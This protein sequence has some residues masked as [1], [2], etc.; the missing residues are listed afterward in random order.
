MQRQTNNGKKGGL[1]KGKSHDDGGIQAVVVDTGQPVE[2]EG[3][4]II[5]NKKSAKKHRKLLSKIN[6]DGGGVPILKKGGWSHD[7]SMRSG[8]K[9]KS[10]SL[11]DY[12]W[13]ISEQPN[14]FI[15]IPKNWTSKELIKEINDFNDSNYEYI[16]SD[17]FDETAD[18]KKWVVGGYENKA[19]ESFGG[20]GS[21]KAKA[22]EKLLAEI[23]SDFRSSFPWGY[24]DV[25]ISG[26]SVTADE[27]HLGDW[28]HDY[29][30]YDRDEDDYQDDDQM[31]WSDK[32]WK[33]YTTEFKKWV[34]SKSWGKRVTIDVDTSEKNWAYFTVTLKKTWAQGMGLY[35]KKTGKPVAKK[36]PSVSKP[37]KSKETKEYNTAFGIIAASDWA[38]EPALKPY[39]KNNGKTLA[40]PKLQALPAD[41]LIALSK[42]ITTGQF[43]P[44]KKTSPKKTGGLYATFAELQKHGVSVI[45]DGVAISDPTMD[46]SGRKEVEIEYY[47]D[48][49]LKAWQEY[50]KGK[51][52]ATKPSSDNSITLADGSIVYE[53]DTGKITGKKD[54][55][56]S[57]VT[58]IRDNWVY[59]DA[60]DGK[61]RWLAPDAF[62]KR[63]EPDVVTKTSDQLKSRADKRD[64]RMQDRADRKQARDDAR[65]A[66]AAKRKA[67]GKPTVEFD[68]DT[69]IKKFIGDKD[70]IQV[71]NISL[72]DHQRNVMTDMFYEYGIKI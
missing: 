12:I 49:I 71:D 63:F 32:S 21:I 15:E 1:L 72:V 8:G 43:A 6:Q 2:L 47:K 3:E 24:S 42:T 59:F 41:E 18:G 55:P 54:F 27:R 40:N 60:G 50:Q 56:G 19:D 53:G 17:D 20:G 30:D 13:S 45:S 22:K 33:Y 44:K 25:E 7:R 26:D 61:R 52:P 62:K 58:K 35:P 5:I 38:N 51:K 9:V 67:D 70:V 48:A 69:A 14:D 28:E 16:V 68:F 36:T 57:T 37:D 64:Q 65:K 46:E 66:R 11:R 31:V 23:E 10:K 34:K 29:D 4:E 39:V